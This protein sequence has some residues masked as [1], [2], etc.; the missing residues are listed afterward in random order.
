[1]RIG[2][3][4]RFLGPEGTGIGRYVENLIKNL[5]IVDEENQ[6]FIFLRSSNYH[7]YQPKAPNFEKVKAD[8]KWYSLKEQLILPAVLNREKLDLVH[9]PHFNIPLLY[10]GKFVVTIHDLTKSLFGDRAS[11]TRSLP[12]FL[13]KQNAYKITINQAMARSKKILVPSEFVKKELV[14]SFDL[15]NEK[16][17]VTYEGAEEFYDPKFVVSEGKTRELFNKYSLSEPYI[18]F[19]GN[20][21]PYKNVDV[22]LEALTKLPTELKFVCVSPRNR[23]LEKLI[24]SAG[25]L[26]IKNRL[27]T[28]G[29][30]SDSDLKVL[31]KK[32]VA[33]VFPSLSEG[34]G[35][36]G[37]EAMGVGCPVISSDKTSLP[38]VYGEAALYFKPDSSKELVGKIEQI[39]K[40]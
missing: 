18:I 28:P 9:F 14:K 30:L 21:F 3:D 38:E 39:M 25:H 20:T 27:T 15:T 1:M 13:A 29:Y 11:S 26:G 33:F 7:L 19:V 24:A 2:I 12:I 34:F 8:A 35:L 31:F 32:A 23:F 10:R 40:D 37:L 6:Y 4:A 36:P 16:I 22:I 5:E 17:R